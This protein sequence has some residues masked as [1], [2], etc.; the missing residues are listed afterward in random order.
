M[1]VSLGDP[2][3][4]RWAARAPLPEQHPQCGTHEGVRGPDPLPVAPTARDVR[5]RPRIPSGSGGAHHAR[6][7]ALRHAALGA[8]PRPPPKQFGHLVRDL[9][10]H[11]MRHLRVLRLPH[12]EHGARSPPPLMRVRSVPRQPPMSRQP[13]MPRT[14]APRHAHV[15]VHVHVHVASPAARTR[16][17]PV[18]RWAARSTGRWRRRTRTPPQ[19]SGTCCRCARARVAAWRAC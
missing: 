16:A 4:S 11:P 3:V 15:H 2:R 9:Y 1:C 10:R 12:Q 17:P 7:V 8:A 19:A 14:C 5:L 18:R 6:E 13:P